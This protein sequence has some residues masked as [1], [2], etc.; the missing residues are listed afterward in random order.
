MTSVSIWSYLYFF[1]YR[2][3]K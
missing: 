2:T 3:S 1:I